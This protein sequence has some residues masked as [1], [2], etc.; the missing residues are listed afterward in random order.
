MNIYHYVGFW[1]RPAKC[2]LDIIEKEKSCMVILTEL[3][4]NDGTSVTNMVENLA[5]D[6]YTNFLQRDYQPSEVMWIEHY[7]EEHYAHGGLLHKETFD[8]VIMTWNGKKFAHPKWLHM[9]TDEIEKLGYN[10][11]YRNA[12]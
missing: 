10:K 11:D 4:D 5:T 12:G 3:P 9:K 6:I 8:E 1:K 7:P 2:G